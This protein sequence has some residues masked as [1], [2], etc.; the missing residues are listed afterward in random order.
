[1]ITTKQRAS[2]RGMANK[3]DTIVHVGKGGITDTIVKQLDDAL[4]ARELVKGKVLESALLTS[5]EVCE[6]L[7]RRTKSAPVQVIGTKFVLYRPNKKLPAD[8]RIHLERE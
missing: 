1:M 8:K 2:L 3:I 5:R 4:T 7:A 6:N